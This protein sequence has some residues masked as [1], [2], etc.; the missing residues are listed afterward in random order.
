MSNQSP[1]PFSIAGENKLSK[2]VWN[3]DSS[4]ASNE[5]SLLALIVK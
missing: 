1:I 4:K 3:I 2:Q 5:T